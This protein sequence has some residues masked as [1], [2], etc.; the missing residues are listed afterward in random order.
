M[1]YHKFL[2]WGNVLLDNHVGKILLCEPRFTLWLC[3]NARNLVRGFNIFG[4][5][6]D[7]TT[8]KTKGRVCIVFFKTL[9][10][11]VCCDLIA[12]G[13][14]LY[15]VWV[16]S[17]AHLHQLRLWGLLLSQH[18]VTSL[19]ILLWSCMSTHMVKYT[20]FDYKLLALYFVYISIRASYFE[21]ICV[22]RWY[23][24]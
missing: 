6:L 5:F 13:N 7:R 20:V 4:I 2:F 1:N 23:Y 11:A 19:W 18:L 10:R 9:L 3:T 16:A 17:S 8:M 15:M 14:T 24:L 22:S 21:I 12:N